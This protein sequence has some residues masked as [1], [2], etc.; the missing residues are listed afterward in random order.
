MERE[1]FER[2]AT[3]FLA[4]FSTGLALVMAEELQPAQRFGAMVAV[5]GSLALYLIVRAWPAAAK[6]VEND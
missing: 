4:V 2:L 3:L 1:K 5:A 6:R